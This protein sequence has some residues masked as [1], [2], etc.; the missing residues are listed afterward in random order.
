MDD[1]LAGKRAGGKDFVRRPIPICF[2]KFQT[3]PRD[4]FF[5]QKP[6]S[7]PK[8][9]LV[10]QC[11]VKWTVGQASKRAARTLLGVPSQFV[12]INF[13]ELVL[14]TWPICTFFVQ[15]PQSSIFTS[16]FTQVV[17]SATMPSEMNSW[18]SGQ[19]IPICFNKF[20]RAGAPHKWPRDTLLFKNLNLHPNCT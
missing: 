8:L 20:Q 13:K 2:N 14:H 17:P 16:I 11:Q 9:Y 19:H 4:S 10:Q 7:S 6:Q 3:W 5:V 18:A 1:P 12:S 15:K